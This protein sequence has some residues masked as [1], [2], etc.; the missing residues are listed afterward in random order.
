LDIL[1][2]VEQTS[3][4]AGVSSRNRPSAVIGSPDFVAAEPPVRPLPAHLTDGFARLPAAAFPELE[5]FP[6]AGRIDNCCQADQD[7]CMSRQTMSFALPESMRKYI[8][9]RVAAGNYG[10][11]SEY[12]RD[13]VRRDQEEQAKKRLRDLIEEGL[14][15]GPGRPRTKADEKELLA[16]ARGEID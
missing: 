9:N 7:A 1:W 14:A 3:R 6:S 11:T 8:D 13:L 16:I 4:V 2:H 5:E 12:I 15:S 10:N